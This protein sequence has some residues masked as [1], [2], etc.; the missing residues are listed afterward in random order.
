M[1]GCGTIE[2]RRPRV[3]SAEKRFESRLIPL[4]ARK[5]RK[6][7]QLIP[8]LYLHGLAE[9][10]FDLALRALLG[11]EAPVSASTVARLKEK[12]HADLARWRQRS[13]DDLEAVYQWVD[14]FTAGLEKEKAAILVLLVAFADGRKIVVTPCPAIASPPRAGPKYFEI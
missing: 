14:G 7:D 12:W 4:L 8:E 5:S 6:V 10:D 3:R 1:R 13:L 9:R 11:E 2:V